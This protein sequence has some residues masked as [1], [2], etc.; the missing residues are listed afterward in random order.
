[1][2]LAIFWLS[3]GQVAV[4]PWASFSPITGMM[5]HPNHQITR[6]VTSR[7]V[8]LVCVLVPCYCGGGALPDTEGDFGT[9]PGK[10]ML[11]TL[12]ISCLWSCEGL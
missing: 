8:L 3:P 10:G 4:I 1:M 7:R 5:Q 6:G 9:D 11:P 2:D 12:H